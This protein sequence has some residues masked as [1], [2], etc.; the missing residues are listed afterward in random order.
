M[1][2]KQ[3]QSGSRQ[4][5]DKWLFFARMAKSRSIAQDLIRSNH[6]RVNGD[7]VSQ[8]SSQVK[9]GD[10]IDL[11]LERRDLVLVVKTGGERR[12]PFEEA[13]L[14]YEDLSPPPEETKR[15]TLFEQAQRAQGSG[16]PTKK[17][18]RET[19]R[20]FPGIDADLD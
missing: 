9:P 7:L 8:P 6:V 15:L 17:E 5:I 12:G 4:R 19:D 11:K 2:E 1:T 14:L 16:R 3:P 13:R 10:R 20:L 18:R